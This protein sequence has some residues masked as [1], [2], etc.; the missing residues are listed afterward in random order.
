MAISPRIKFLLSNGLKGLIWLSVLIGAYLLFEEIVIS[1]NPDV[2]VQRF[3]SQPEI[4]Y[5][6]YF[7]SELFF[8]ILPPELFM[9]WAL[10]KGGLFQYVI[11]V[12]FF[13]MVSYALGYLNFLV[14]QFIYKR[15]IFRYIR[16]RFFKVSWPQLR[17][18]GLFLIVVAALTPLPWAAVCLLVG[19]AGY[20]TK[21]F[22]IYAL[23]RIF[24]FAVYG[25]IIYQTH[26]L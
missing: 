22:L 2:W 15:V 10:N 4:I 18:Y 5:L 6:V 24:R 8:G 21:N 19:S 17:K 13:G 20:P 25:L 26:H 7:F 14:G 1:K 16:R 9:I 23:S 3:Y 11:H 12:T